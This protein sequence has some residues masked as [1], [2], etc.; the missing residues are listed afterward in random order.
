MA[1]AGTSVEQG[2]VVADVASQIFGEAVQTEYVIGE[3]LRRS[4]TEFD[5]NQAAVLDDLRSCVESDDEPQADFARFRETPLAAWIEETFGLRREA[6]TNRLIRQTPQSLRGETGVAQQLAALTGLSREQC[7]GAIK[8]YLYAGSACRDPE[9]EFPL[10]AFRLHQFITRG[11]TVW[12]SLEDE[13]HRVVT[14]RGQQ[15]VPGDRDKILLPLVFCRHCGHPYYRVDRPS[16]GQ[17]GPLLPRLEFS[18]TVS[19]NV[20]S[21]Y[22]YLSSQNP[23]PADANDVVERVPEDWVE[24]HRT[25]RR[26]KRNKSVPE[27]MR[28]GTTGQRDPNGLSVAFLKA[29]FQFCLNPACNVA[30]NARQRSDVGKL[31]T[32]GID[33]RSTATT[34]LALSTILKLRVDESLETEARKLLSFTDNRQDASLQAGH[35]NDFVEVGLIR[36]G[37]YRAMVRLGEG[38]LRYD[39]LVHHVE[40]AL[41]L[42]ASLYANDPELRGPALEES[43]RALR[44]VLGYLLYRDL[45]RG[46]RVT[47]P[48]LEQCGLLEIDYLAIDEVAGEH[49]S[50]ADKNAH[51]ALIA[52]TPEQRMHII[53]VLPGPSAA[54]LGG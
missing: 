33:G 14:L 24:S 23:W 12:A 1:S 32:I 29:P 49:A 39:E 4:T 13:E 20:D 8:R 45:E 21:G 15:Y 17:P 7:E 27:L 19:D 41:N 28:V 25:G 37:L 50:W 3:T 30:Y 48:N 44:S 52:A 47:S 2:R 9:T 18:L 22:L 54:Q 42:P 46:W 35:F 36:S 10:F 51:A 31:S 26:V 43:R 16:H 11:D 38:G 40:R 34:I 6:E 53:R 5:F